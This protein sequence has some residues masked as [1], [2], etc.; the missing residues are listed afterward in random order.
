[1]PRWTALGAVSQD[2]RYAARTLR[3][4]PGFSV[5]A[6]L[7]LAVGI[8]ANS[9]IFTVIEAALL[10][11]LPFPSPGELVDVYARDANGQRNYVSQPDLDDWRAMAH[12]WQGVASWVPQSVN[13]TGLDEPQ[14][15]L[16]IFMSSNLLPVLGVAPA[17]GR[18]LAPG[19][20]RPGGARVA[21]IS[22]RLWRTR[23]GSDGGI[24]GRTVQFNGEPYTVVGVLPAGFVFPFI[25]VDVYLPAF[26]YPNY[27]LDRNRASCAVIGRLRTGVSLQEAQAEMNGIAS[28]LAGAYPVSNQGRG[29]LVK[30]LKEDL[31]A[32]LKPAAAALTAAVAFVLLIACANVAGLLIARMMT[33]TRE[34]AIRFALGA[35]R[36]RVISHV[37]AE[38]VLIASLGGAL[39]LLIA[40]WAAPAI[41]SV[42]GPYLPEGVSVTFDYGA[43]FFTAAVSL[44]CALLI[45]AIP[46]FQSFTPEQL[47]AGRGAGTAAASNRSRSALA[48]LEIA[49][50]M[51]L[52]TGSGLMMKSGAELARA[53]TGFD[54]HNLLT[55]AYR[56][57]RNKYPSGAQQTQ[58]H[59]EVTEKIKAVPGVLAAASVRAVPLGGNGSNSGFWRTDAPEPPAAERPQALLNFVDP[60]FFSTMRIPVLQGRAFSEHD[61]AEGRYVIVVNQTLARRY[62]G[63]QNPI[64]RHLRLDA[65]GKTGEIVGVVGDVKQFTL[66]DPPSAQIYGALAQNPFIFN[67][68]AVRTSGDPL[69]LGNEVR[70]AIRTVDKDQPVW[71]VSSFDEIL[72]R[73]S[74]F[75]Q[76]VTWTLA[77]YALIALLLAAIGIFGVISYAVTQRTAEIG[78]RVALGAQRADVMRLVMGEAITMTAVGCISGAGAAMW[79]AQYLRTQLYGVSPLDA[80]VYACVAGVLAATS[81]AACAA[82]VRRAMKVDP[83]VALGYEN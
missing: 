78:V 4:S 69:K 21:V 2:L 45:G 72:A 60:D 1:M 47:R 7:T 66:K 11:P 58:F 44:G 61:E 40:V 23:F 51:A 68:L 59:R 80:G 17:M 52:L 24:L 41:T 10:K 37:L 73:Q 38:A 33:R 74:R 18:G 79:L 54:A 65:N 46:A 26:K 82:P 20:D 56:V 57:P 19:E 81:I 49:L 16:G 22:D 14:R 6:V 30:P 36:A 83:I 29:A 12:S 53:K 67:S 13:L 63:G 28:R 35:G 34:R 9:A 42:I 43:A 48:A 55:L 75:G 62:F 76:M 5:A 77:A 3:K 39:G 27:S 25:D 8:G 64:G 50:A 71:S 31:I 15:I 70:R 32:D